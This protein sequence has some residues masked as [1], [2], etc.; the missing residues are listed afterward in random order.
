[1]RA[2]PRAS[3]A[4]K[5]CPTT[6]IFLFL[7]SRGTPYHASTCD[8]AIRSYIFCKYAMSCRYSQTLFPSAIPDRQP[9]SALCPA[10][11]RYDRK[12]GSPHID[13]TVLYCLG[14][15]DIEQPCCAWRHFY[16][17]H[18]DQGRRVGKYFAGLRW[19]WCQE[20][21]SSGSVYGGFCH[22]TSR[23]DDCF[24]ADSVPECWGCRFQGV[25]SRIV[26]KRVFSMA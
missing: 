15:S 17:R 20:S 10:A 25:G 2:L 21:P 9:V 26:Q 24:P 13:R 18:P 19:L 4:D 3:A 12:T 1:M 6:P 5:V 7:G 14:A 23:L 22:C 11:V 8:R 16:W